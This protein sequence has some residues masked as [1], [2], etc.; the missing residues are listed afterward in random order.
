M[1]KKAKTRENKKV[2][3]QQNCVTYRNRKDDKNVAMFPL[4]SILVE[5]RAFKERACE[6]MN[7]I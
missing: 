3:A 1:L 2:S 5:K 7:K 4:T 6:D